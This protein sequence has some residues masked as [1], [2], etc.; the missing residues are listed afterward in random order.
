MTSAAIGEMDRVKA[1]LKSIWAAGDYDRF[2]RLDAAGIHWSDVQG[3][4][5][6]HRAVRDAV[7]GFMGR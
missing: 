1:R 5:K 2:S 3:R 4:I 7:A 6:V